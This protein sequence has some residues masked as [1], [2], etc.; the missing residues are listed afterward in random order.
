MNMKPVLEHSTQVGETTPIARPRTTAKA[1]EIMLKLMAE[2]VGDSS[3]HVIAHHA[4][5]AEEGEK[6][7]AQ[8]G[9]RFNCAEL[10]LTEFTPGMGVHAGP[11]ILGF[12]YYAD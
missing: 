10:Y 2:R 1:V 8:I 9:A 3:V 4:D 12:S 6:L 11:G 7:K 5:E